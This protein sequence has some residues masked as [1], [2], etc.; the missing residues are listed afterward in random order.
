M[1]AALQMCDPHIATT[2]KMNQE[3]ATNEIYEIIRDIAPDIIE[4]LFFC[5]WR[6]KFSTCF[7]RYRPVMTDEGLCFT[8]NDLNSRDIYTDE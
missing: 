5:K 1:K 2:L 3:F 7:Q 6:N 8:F 4:S